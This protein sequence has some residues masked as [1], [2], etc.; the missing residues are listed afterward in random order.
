MGIDTR[1]FIFPSLSFSLPSSFVHL[2]M[3][4]GCTQ[5]CGCIL[6]ASLHTHQGGSLLFH[7]HTMTCTFHTWWP[8]ALWACYLMKWDLLWEGFLNWMQSAGK[9]LLCQWL[10]L[11]PCVSPGLTISM[12][13]HY[14]LMSGCEWYII[15]SAGWFKLVASRMIVIDESSLGESISRGCTLVA[16]P[17]L[18]VIPDCCL[19]CLTS[20]AVP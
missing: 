16:H 11:K 20:L 3:R 13:N 4:A 18:V 2:C 7:R 17:P 5:G 1:S 8:C 6:K 9:Y 15:S 14:C 10:A 19:G 12:S